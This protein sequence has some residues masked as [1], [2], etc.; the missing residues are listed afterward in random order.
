[1]TA[2]LRWGFLGCGRISSD[3]V[4]AMKSL[5]DVVFQ[6]CAAR[7]LTSAQAFATEH[8]IAKAY[9]SY[10]ALVSDADVDVV[11]I[12]TLH[13]WHYEHTVLALNHGKHVL[14]EKPMAM[15]VTQASA[16]IALAR[17]K[18]LF[19]MEGMWTRFFPAIRHVRQLLADKEVGDVHHVHA[20]FGCQFDADNARMWHN[21]LGGGGLLDI[22]IYPL[23]FATMVFGAE[24][25]KV[26]STGKLNDGGVDIHNSVTLEYSD[27]RFATIEYTMLATMDE[28]LT[29]T[30]SKGRIHLP[31]PAHTATEVRLV[32]Y[33][34]DGSQKE[35]KSLFPWPAPAP[36]VTFNYGGS[37]GF[38]YEAETVIEAIQSKQLE[39]KEYPLDESLQI[40]TI[41][42]KIRKDVGLVTNSMGG[43]SQP[44][45]RWG[46][47][48]CGNIANDF[49]NAMKGTANGTISLAACAA[50]SLESAEKFAATHGFARAYGSYEELCAD[51][52]VDV[53][54]VATI[55][56]MHFDHVTL[57][58]NHGKHVLVEKP[59]TMNA[60]QTAS[61]I[62]LAKAKKLFLM[63]GV[64][65]RF[66]PSIKFVRRLLAEER[67]G[68]VH[69]VHGDI[70]IS[71]VS[72]QTEANFRSSSGDGALLGIGIYPLS[73]VTM[74]F[75][76]KPL[77]ITATGK[78]SS[79]G[80]DV[81]GSAT[82]EYSGNRFGTFNFT[83]LAELGNSVTIT[84][85]KGR[86]RIPSPAHS[87]TEVVV[88]Q[89][90]EDGSH[91]E[92]TTKFPWPTPSS[93]IA[94]PFK[95]PGSEA[96]VYEAEAVTEAIRD[97]RL[98]CEEYPL[99][100][101]LAIAEIMD[102][103]REAI[104][105]VYAADSGGKRH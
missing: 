76:T 25:E 54:Y 27:S 39:S 89:F 42:D 84:G 11:Y 16:A 86:I 47:I 34:E 95:Y 31:A 40:M 21:E 12:G 73:F 83:A 48:G 64:W 51:P 2:P 52:E 103:I 98:Q 96:L 46:F 8:G 94:T 101:S 78:T 5:D 55:H 57:A 97:G 68:A 74:V 75:G 3:F 41:M 26:T 29:I 66:F 38:R 30:G 23:A 56:L 20:A 77:K 35:T 50:R 69:H 67:I 49:V 70:G 91:Q 24:P 28:T 63:E 65:T 62:E 9:D 58:L 105:V 37:E 72:S 10:E 99:E 14:V 92:T 104:G 82:L 100:E 81:Y 22:G 13:P 17:E 43:D 33:A 79:G 53:V 85:S 88:T 6:A 1:M 7:S 4:S 44:P 15:N 36:G 102:E 80:A 60:K 90:L 32:K 45:L 93:S 59:M 19:L 87:A 61:V 71:F 18:K